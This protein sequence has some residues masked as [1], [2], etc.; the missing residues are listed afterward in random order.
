MTVLPSLAY[1]E[2]GSGLIW[3]CVTMRSSQFHGAPSFRGPPRDI[4]A[5]RFLQ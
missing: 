3:L 4:E 2:F 1:Y 5:D